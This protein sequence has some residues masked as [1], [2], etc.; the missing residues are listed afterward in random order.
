[1]DAREVQDLEMVELTSRIAKIESTL[2]RVAGDHI[3]LAKE[4][5]EI[6]RDSEA[7]RDRL[8]GIDAFHER[9][10][11][12]GLGF[13]EVI[14]AGILTFLTASIMFGLGL[15]SRSRGKAGENGTND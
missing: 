7:V 14:L 2:E 9:L 1:V 10:L 4:L 3:S 8:K 12:S 11:S 6:Q 15:S 5:T 13:L